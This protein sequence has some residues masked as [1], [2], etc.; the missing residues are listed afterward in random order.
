MT[1]N[2]VTLHSYPQSI[3]GKPNYVFGVR[4]LATATDGTNQAEHN[5]HAIFQPKDVDS[6]FTPYETLTE[7]Q[8]IAWVQEQYPEEVIQQLL[9]EKIDRMSSPPESLVVTPPPWTNS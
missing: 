6:D 2:V 3:P 7:D 5:G 8:V 4:W 9:Q 1:W